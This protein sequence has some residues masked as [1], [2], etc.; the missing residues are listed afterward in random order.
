MVKFS[1]DVFGTYRRG[2]G[3]KYRKGLLCKSDLKVDSNEK[4]GGSG[5]Q[6]SL[7]TCM[8]LWRSRVI[9]ILNVLFLHKNFFLF[10]FAT[11]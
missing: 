11:A 4:L 7:S 3:E 8:G 1:T 2:I 6:Q 9:C 5:S 10:P